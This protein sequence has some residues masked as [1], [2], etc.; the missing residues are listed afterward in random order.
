[1]PGSYAPLHTWLHVTD[2]PSWHDSAFYSPHLAVALALAFDQL[3]HAE[4]RSDPYFDAFRALVPF[5]DQ[6]VCLEQRLNME[7]ALALAFAGD[8]SDTQALE[9][10]FSA[11]D[12]AERLSDWGAQAEIGYLAGSIWHGMGLFTDA[13]EVYRDALIALHRLERDGDLADPVLQLD[14]VLRSAWCTWELGWFVLC[15]HHVDEAYA[16][17]ATRAP[18]AAEEAASLAWL[19]AQLARVFGQPARALNL[20][21]AAADLLLTHGRLVNVGRVHTILAESAL[22]LVEV[23]LFP[24]TIW[25]LRSSLVELKAIDGMSPKGLLARAREAA[26][27]GLKT[28]RAAHDPIGAAMAELAVRRAARLSHPRH[29]S[30]SGLNIAGRL[31]RTAAR[32]N[33][34]SLLGRSE[35]TLADELLAVGRMSEA[36]FTYHR[37]FRRLQEHQL[38]GLAFWPQ[39]ALERLQDGSS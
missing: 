21:A 18:D 2:H 38:G 23:R 10:L 13:Y 27:L 28:A 3:N 22:D 16:L 37:A 19:D 9:C 29:G 15:R 31:L 25:D 14:L 26:D 8:Q 35:M 1:M 32:L 11:W 39:R 33:D 34:Q 20:A 7:F 4:E 12:I 5:R 36:R 17:R 30:E 6:L 24:A